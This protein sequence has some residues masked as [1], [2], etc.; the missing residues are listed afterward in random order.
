MGSGSGGSFAW[1]DDINLLVLDEAEDGGEEWGERG[2]LP[3]A[4]AREECER[5][6]RASLVVHSRRHVHRRRT[7]V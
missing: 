7:W 3:R 4:A 1:G 6:R 5:E 2:C